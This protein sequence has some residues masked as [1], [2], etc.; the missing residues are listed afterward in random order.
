ML[1]V[2]ALVEAFRSLP[3]EGLARLASQGRV[4]RFPAGSVLMQ[5]GDIADCLYVVIEGVVRAERSHQE[6][7]EPLVLA[8][9]GPGEVVGEMGI[10]EGEPRSATVIANVD[11]RAIEISAQ[12]MADILL[13]HRDVS[14]A[15]LRLLSHRLRNV[16]EMVERMARRSRN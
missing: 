4:R 12:V 16:D 15:L 7:T 14:T 1:D 6:L 3:Q 8:E 9:I 5:Q 11:T 13:E 2:L 10:L